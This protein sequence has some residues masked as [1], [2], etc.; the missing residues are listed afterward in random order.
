MKTV[1]LAHDSIHTGNLIL[2]NAQHSYH[3]GAAA[4]TYAPVHAAEHTVLLER[5]AVS[6]LSALMDEIDGWGG[7][8]A[9]SGW[10]SLE[11]QRELYARSLTEHGKEFTQKFVAFPGCSEHQTGLAIDLAVKKDDID[12]ICPDFPYTGICQT[13]RERAARF[14]FV[15]RY[16]CGKEEITGIAQEPWHFRYVGTP[17]AEIMASNHLVL[18][19]YHE[20]LKKYPYGERHYL[21][22]AQGASFAVSYLKAQT[23]GDT[24]FEIADHAAVSVSG[25]NVDGYIITERG[26]PD[27]TR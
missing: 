12:F 26:D 17:H 9:V 2:V 4:H 21:Y 24:R 22:A 7:I 10:R 1:I 13:F 11:E 3:E 23:E 25:N 20:F 18:E 16:P 5:N 14:G 6:M 8:C 15:E 27:G 19:E